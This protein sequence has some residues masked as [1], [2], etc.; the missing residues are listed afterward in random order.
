MIP[1]FWAC[2]ALVA[3]TYA[4][5]P[6]CMWLRARVAPRPVAV[7]AARPLPTVSVVMP[8]HDG[9]AMVAAK[10]AKNALKHPAGGR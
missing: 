9:A 8:V 3:F 10:L 7:D 2:A 1:L 5:Y 6:L 4:G